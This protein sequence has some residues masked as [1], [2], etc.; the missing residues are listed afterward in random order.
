[1]ATYFYVDAQYVVFKANIKGHR[2]MLE[3]LIKFD[4][5]IHCNLL[6]KNLA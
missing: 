5:A 2:A 6:Q 1:M 4:K 3:R